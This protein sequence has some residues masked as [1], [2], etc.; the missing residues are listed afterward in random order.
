MAKIRLFPISLLVILLAVMLIFSS[1]LIRAEEVETGINIG[2]KAPGFTLPDL[3][4]NE[5]SLDDLRG[6]KVFLNFWASWCGPCEHEMPDI[7]KL[8]KEYEDEVAVIA[9]NMGE[10]KDDVDQF[11]SSQDLNMPVLL[12]RNQSLAEKYAVQAIPTTYI[13]DEEGIITEKH[14]GLIEY[15]K[16]KELLN[17]ED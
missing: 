7:E 6:K 16:M 12:D 10:K 1:Q 15:D 5:I 3:E 2:N 8:H 13:L 11:L 17:I 14:V 4:K 9:V